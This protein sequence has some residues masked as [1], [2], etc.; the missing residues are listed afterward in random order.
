[1]EDCKFHNKVVKGDIVFLESH[2]FREHDYVEKLKTAFKHKLIESIQEHRSAQWL[3]E[4]LAE[5]G[6]ISD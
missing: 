5:L 1:M 6:I 3:S 2:I 4:K